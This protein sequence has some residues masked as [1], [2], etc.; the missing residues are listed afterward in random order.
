[1]QRMIIVKLVIDR[2]EKLNGGMMSSSPSAANAPCDWQFIDT[3][4][5]W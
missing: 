5:Q 1:M 2:R 3:M 4:S